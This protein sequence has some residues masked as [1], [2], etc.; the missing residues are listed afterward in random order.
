MQ[1][2]CG[3]KIIV[4]DVNGNK[5][6]QIEQEKIPSPWEILWKKISP[7]HKSIDMPNILD[8]MSHTV[9]LSSIQKRKK[10]KKE[11]DWYLR[12]PVH[13][14][15]LLQFKAL[16]EIVQTGYLYTKEKLT[17]E[18]ETKLKTQPKKTN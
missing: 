17:P 9:V 2:I 4:V 5:N 8:I 12:P 10:I 1:E 11:A 13:Q 7:F 15:K 16:E 14:Y 18:I 3:G 6:F